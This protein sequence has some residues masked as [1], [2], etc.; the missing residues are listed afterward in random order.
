M[1]ISLTNIY[2]S[3]TSM[4]TSDGSQPK[5]HRAPGPNFISALPS[6][7]LGQIMAHSD[8]DLAYRSVSKDFKEAAAYNQKINDQLGLR[9]AWRFLRQPLDN[10]SNLV[11]YFMGDVASSKASAEVLTSPAR[12]M[13]Y[14]VKNLKLGEAREITSKP[15]QANH[16]WSFGQVAVK[17][18]MDDE[19]FNARLYEVLDATPKLETLSFYRNFLTSLPKSLFSLVNL[20]ELQIDASNNLTNQNLADLGALVNLT[21][22]IF[23]STPTVTRIPPKMGR[24]VN[25]QRLEISGTSATYL[26]KEIGQLHKLEYANF[27]MPSLERIPDE[28]GAISSLLFIDLYGCNLREFPL[29]DD[30]ARFADLRF[31]FKE[32]FSASALQ[33]IPSSHASFLQ[34]HRDLRARY[35]RSEKSF[36]PAAVMEA[37]YTTCRGGEFEELDE[38]ARDELNDLMPRSEPA[39]DKHLKF[40]LRL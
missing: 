16:G 24:L 4:F 25:L 18:V 21:T 26:P 36:P 12:E 39:D 34:Y 3:L 11:T 1:Q 37:W 17:V 7:L 32:L 20:T 38:A 30:L 14:H 35:M 22:L 29:P 13:L 10:K 27:S 40:Y 8:G 6:E 5:T 9:C 28:F 19:R 31:E 33:K 2:N 23:G 15:Y